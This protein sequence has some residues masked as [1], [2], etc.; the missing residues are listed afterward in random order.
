M[1]FKLLLVLATMAV[2]LA[3]TATGALAAPPDAIIAEI[4]GRSAGHPPFCP[5]N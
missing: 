2:L 1:K 5:A 3:L 4:C